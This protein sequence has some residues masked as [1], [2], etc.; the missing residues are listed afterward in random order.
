MDDCVVYH[1]RSVNNKLVKLVLST[2]HI[3]L[4]YIDM[5]MCFCNSGLCNQDIL[6]HAFMNLVIC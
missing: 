4:I 6:K 5:I 1:Q 3:A 2:L